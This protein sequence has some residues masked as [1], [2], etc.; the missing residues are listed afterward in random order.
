MFM[1][2]TRDQILSNKIDDE[3]QL[4]M[5]EVTA[6]RD[7]YEGSFYSFEYGGQNVIAEFIT[8]CL[9][10]AKHSGNGYQIQLLTSPQTFVDGPCSIKDTQGRNVDAFASTTRS[11]A[12]NSITIE[13]VVFK[14][15]DSVFE[16]RGT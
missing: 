1:K 13:A 8:A 9:Q 3:R 4:A 14:P 11:K 12:E 5:E 16:Q 2:Q 6:L 15:T 10:T 7:R